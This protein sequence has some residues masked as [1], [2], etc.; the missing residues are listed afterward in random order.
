MLLF[1][2][3]LYACICSNKPA[4]SSCSK[5]LQIRTP[6]IG[7]PL[8]AQLLGNAV[9]FVPQKC[10]SQDLD[11]RAARWSTGILSYLSKLIILTDFMSFNESI[12]RITELRLSLPLCDQCKKYCHKPLKG[13]CAL[14]FRKSRLLLGSLSSLML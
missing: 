1:L 5:A 7:Q 3:W 12:N 11:E 8:A 2:A 13:M 4:E 14:V 9:C 10:E 6:G